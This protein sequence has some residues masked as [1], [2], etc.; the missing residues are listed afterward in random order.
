MVLSSEHWSRYW[1]QGHLT[2][3]PY[4]FEK[5][6]DAEFEIFWHDQFDRLS[7]GDHVLDVCSGNGSIALL[8]ARFA[9]TTSTAVQITATDAANIDPAVIVAK[10]PKEQAL[11]ESIE[12]IGNTRLEALN[13]A[14]GQFQLITSQ[15]GIEYTDWGRSSSVIDELL[16]PGGHFVSVSHAFDSAIVQ[17]MGAQHPDY[18]FLL[19]LDLFDDGCL[20]SDDPLSRREFVFRIDEAIDQIHQRFSS[21]GQAPVLAQYGQELEQILETLVTDFA[22][23]FEHFQR[24]K[25]SLIN[26]Y[27]VSADFNSVGA[28]LAAQRN[29]SDAF[30][31]AGLQLV[32]HESLTDP[33][34]L[35]LADT[36]VFM[37][38]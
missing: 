1:R 38:P 24:I 22:A 34:Q 15:F 35:K 12:F 33:D 37:K 29:W 11:I 3:L 18:V 9:Q 13:L 2:S 25:R 31:T 16:S 7:A 17:Q 32:A 36:F 21:R 8:A 28:R 10:H 6:Y 20:P 19:S 27:E 26:N 5:N 4:R 14:P 23:G 30:V